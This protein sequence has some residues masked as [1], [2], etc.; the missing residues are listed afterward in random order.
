M[1]FIVAGISSCKEDEGAANDTFY[2]RVTCNESDDTL[3]T[4]NG[5]IKTILNTN[6]AISSCHAGSNIKAGKNY[7]N[8]T[9]AVNSFSN[10]LCSVYR[11]GGCDPMPDGAAKLSDADIH[12]LTCWAKN[13]FPE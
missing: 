1:L 3:N 11:E 7:S 8:Y 12:D 13:N 4:Y 5:K 6:C 2:S 9:Q 10:T